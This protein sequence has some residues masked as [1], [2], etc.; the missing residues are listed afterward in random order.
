MAFE[1]IRYG[2]GILISKG[3]SEF[4]GHIRIRHTPSLWIRE[5]DC[6]EFMSLCNHYGITFTFHDRRRIGTGSTAYEAVALHNLAVYNSAL[7]TVLNKKS[8]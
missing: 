6:E 1:H 4:E 7:S 3:E 2:P 5:K 8:D